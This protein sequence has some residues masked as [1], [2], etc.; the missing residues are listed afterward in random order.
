MPARPS[1]SRRADIPADVLAGL[2]RGEEATQ[3]LAEGL[4][5]DF[6]ALLRQAL[7]MSHEIDPSL[8]ITR[9]MEIASAALCD[10]QVAA[11]REHPSDTVRGWAAFAIGRDEKQP[12]RD[13]LTRLAPF[14]EDPHFGVREWAWLAV[15]PAIV[16]EPLVAVEVLAR[17]SESPVAFRRRFASE[18]TRPRGVWCAHIELFKTDPSLALPLL[19]PMHADP[20]KYVQ[21]SVGNWLNDAAKS[22]PDWVR[23]LCRGWTGHRAAEATTKICKRALRSLS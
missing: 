6:S 17:W 5:I 21:D 10:A 22:Q 9:R 8:G 3:T 15:R 14:A 12:L 11:A 4:A 20:E 19:E 13:R 16:A 18:A 2:N 1:Y 23:G 7:G